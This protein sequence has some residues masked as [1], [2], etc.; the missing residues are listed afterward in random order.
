MPPCTS[1]CNANAFLT[2]ITNPLGQLQ[3]AVYDYYIG[4]P[5]Q[6]TDVAN[7][8]S[9]GYSLQD[10][11]GRLISIN[12]PD[13]G[14]VTYGY[15]DSSNTIAT[16]TALTAASDPHCPGC[17]AQQ[18]SSEIVYD[19]L[20][21]TTLAWHTEAAGNSAV[22]TK[23]DGLGRV[24]QVSNPYLLG[25]SP[26]YWTTTSYDGLS[27]VIQVTAPDG[28]NSYTGYS[29]NVTTVV[30]QAGKWRQT[31]TDAAGRLIQVVEDPAASFVAASGATMNNAPVPPA[32]GLL[33]YTTTYTY[34]ALDDL[35]GVNQSG[36]TRTFAYDGAKRLICAQNPESSAPS[37]SC[38]SLPASGV[39][40]YAYDAN[41]NLNSHT[42]ANGISTSS[43]YDKLNRLIQKTYSDGTP[44]ESYC[45]DG[46]TSATS[47]T[48]TLGRDLHRRAF[49][50][51]PVF[52]A[53][54]HLGIQW[55]LLEQFQRVR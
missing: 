53:P 36:Q 34:D 9:T 39:D 49:A 24:Y 54:A 13:N 37:T 18:K 16:T 3:T 10:P 52:P 41:G 42:N 12:Y 11:L 5:T 19:G 31:T 15:L 32:T 25:S 30:D 22:Q 48:S 45:Y 4:K 51:R 17:A 1:G 2:L 21:R 8:V 44:A 50:A 28:S 55:R 6:V 26:S 29:G 20:G 23:Y 27:R 40:R 43:V 38:A 14:S 33:Q 46:S 47:A 7:S 35:L